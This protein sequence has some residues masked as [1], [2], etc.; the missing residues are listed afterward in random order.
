MHSN[1]MGNGK[2]NNVNIPVG[3]NWA[4][5]CDPRSNCIQSIKPKYWQE[6]GFCSGGLVRSVALARH[7]A[8]GAISTR[9]TWRLQPRG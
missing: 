8:V 1:K 3:Q 7:G 2:E 9:R 6:L 4:A 5:T